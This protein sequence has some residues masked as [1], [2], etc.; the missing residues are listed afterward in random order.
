MLSERVSVHLTGRPSAR[1]SHAT[2]TASG[3]IIFAPNPPPMSGLTTRTWPGSSPSSPAATILPM[4]GVCEVAQ[5]VRRPS[6]P[7]TA[8]AERGSSG[9]AA[10]RWLTTTPET[11]RSQPSNSPSSGSSV[12]LRLATFDP[13]SGKSNTSSRTA[14]STERTAGSG[15]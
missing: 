12:P 6:S 3:S 4:C 11:T 1:A 13:T 8:A 7:T 9:A 2:S 10:S 5:S 14:S 15:S